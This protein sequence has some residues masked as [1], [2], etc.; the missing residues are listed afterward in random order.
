MSVDI[1]YETHS[2]TEDNERGIAIG[3]LPGRLSATG[4]RLAA[5]LGDRRREDHLAGVFVSDLHRAVETA[6]IA[7][8]GTAI[9]IHRD[10]RLRACDYGELNGCPVTALEG[11]RSRHIDTPYPGGGQSYRWRVD[12]AKAA[13][14]GDSRP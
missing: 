3:R 6:G 13:P 2:L 10:P 12:G 4:R 9:P 14:P 7:F 1:V 8:G 11:R 5:R